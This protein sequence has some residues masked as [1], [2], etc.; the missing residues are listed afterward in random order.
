MIVDF[1]AQAAPA[2]WVLVAA[3]VV[4]ALLIFALVDPELTEV[5][6]GDVQI[7]VATAALAAIVLGMLVPDR[8]AVLRDLG[9]L[10]G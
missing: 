5:Y 7:L 2:L 6:L 4:L 1:A 3:L 8:A 9:L 10:V